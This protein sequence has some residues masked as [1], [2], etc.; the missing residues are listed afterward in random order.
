MFAIQLKFL[1]EELIV[2]ESPRKEVDQRVMVIGPLNS[3]YLKNHI[4][5]PFFDDRIARKRLED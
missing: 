2:N 3:V 5:G 1:D 4:S